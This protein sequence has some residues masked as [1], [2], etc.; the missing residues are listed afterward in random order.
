MVVALCILLAF[1]IETPAPHRDARERGR[2]ILE[3]AIDALGG[4]TRLAALDNWLVS[5]V[6]RENLSGELQGIASDVPTW[7][8][9][10]ETAA[11]VRSTGAIAWERKSERSDRSLRWRRVIYKPEELGTI[12][13]NTR[14]VSQTKERVSEAVRTAMARR[15]PHVL[16]RELSTT[17]SAIRETGTRTWGGVVHDAVQVI[18]SSGDSLNLIFN[19]SPVTLRRVEYPLFVPGLGIVTVGWE[20]QHWRTSQHLGMIPTGHMIDVSGTPFQEL[21]YTR[22]TA[23]SADAQQF[24]ESPSNLG[25][26]AQ[27]TAPTPAAFPATGEVAPGVH[28]LNLRG[29]V[30]M[31]VE[32]REFVVALEAPET[33]PGLQAIPASGQ[34]GVGLVTRE[35]LAAIDR[36]FPT[37]P[38]RYLVV[39]HHHGDHVG[40]V[41]AFAARGA[42]IVA[43]PDAAQV[44]AKLLG[45]PRN[46]RVPMLGGSV[47]QW[48][49]NV[50]DDRET[51]S[52]G[53]RTLEI[54][55]VGK[56]P[57]TS[58]NLV[59][60]LPAERLV[61]QGDLFYFTQGAPFPPSG[62]T[63]M[64]EFF[65]EWLAKRGMAP[66][67]VY[68]VHNRGAAGPDALATSRR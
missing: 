50:V 31:V 3:A 61:F 40:G 29:F 33:H 15:I 52:D 64:N 55:N 2:A 54:M 46:E 10:E 67:A 6:G 12:D 20:W 37:K 57:H 59:A 49:I 8:S 25:A 34:E 47:P 44:A 22:Y 13:W 23:G 39:S 28:V 14:R 60:W 36:L 58:E 66:R 19:R 32:F 26:S 7:R 18:T 38:V 62:R 16:L 9:H 35:Y 51:I 42:R 53:S 4:A 27:S 5:G 24:T 48:T 45:A 30:V 41:R 21:R 1:A 11:I 56:N 17:A 63:T 65:A 43:T 68:G